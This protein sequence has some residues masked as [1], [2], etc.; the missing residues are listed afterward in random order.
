MF[1]ERAAGLGLC[2]LLLCAGSP[3][4]A[5]AAEATSGYAQIGPLRM[6]YEVRGEGPALLVLHGGG[7]T[8]DTTYGAILP[9]LARTRTVIAPEQQGHGHTADVDRP[10]SFRQMADDTAALIEKLGYRQVDVVGFSNGGSV[11]MELAIRHPEHVRRLVIGS[12]YYR[13]DGLR[14]ELLRSFRTADAASMPEVYRRAY[15]AVAPNPADLPKLTPKLMGNL[16]SFEGWTDAEL[17]SI[18]AP[19]MILQANNDVAPLEHIAAL[20][21]IIPGAQ[22]VVLPG[23]HGGYLGEVMAASPGSRLPTYTVGMITEFLDAP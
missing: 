16:L 10:L 6:Y 19:T 12:V 7:S 23:G 22:V 2:L 1:I 17:A 5:R 14:P 18:K 11:A 21:R 13:R 3:I 8:I 9:D 20:A 4:A 15:L